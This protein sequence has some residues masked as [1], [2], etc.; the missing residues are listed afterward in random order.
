MCTMVHDADS[1]HESLTGSNGDV[2]D[3]DGRNLL[4][5][6]ATHITKKSLENRKIDRIKIRRKATENIHTALR[7][8]NRS[9]IYIRNI[10][11]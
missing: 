3:I 11:S 2:R 1:D 8:Q 6:L 5:V 4:R 9:V 10:S 7:F